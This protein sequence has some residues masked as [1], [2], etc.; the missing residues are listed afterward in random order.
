MQAHQRCNE[1]RL[2]SPAIEIPKLQKGA[3]ICAALTGHCSY[4]EG[5][6]GRRTRV[7]RPCPGLACWWAFGSAAPLTTAHCNW[8]AKAAGNESDNSPAMNRWA[9]V[10]P[11]LAS[12]RIGT[13][14]IPPPCHQSASIGNTGGVHVVMQSVPCGTYG[15]AVGTHLYCI[16]RMQSHRLKYVHFSKKV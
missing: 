14:Y 12:N 15:K 1:R 16:Y 3:A 7:A 5:D 6:P 10:N 9:I 2:G 11:A 13:N 4:W 8:L